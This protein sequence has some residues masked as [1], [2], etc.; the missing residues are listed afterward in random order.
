[1]KRGTL[2]KIARYSW[3]EFLRMEGE[4]REIALHDHRL[5]ADGG[6]AECLGKVALGVH[7]HGEDADSAAGGDQREG[8]RDGGLARAP[9][10]GDKDDP[11]AKELIETGAPA[12]ARGG[13]QSEAPLTAARTSLAWPSGWT[14]RHS[15]WTPPSGPIRNVERST[16]M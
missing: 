2:K 7:L 12:R 15:R 10:A 16:P 13:R 14:F 8:R 9:L 5:E 11:L 6:M 1:M 4:D 3:N